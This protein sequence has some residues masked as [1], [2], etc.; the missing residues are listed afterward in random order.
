MMVER[1]LEITLIYVDAGI[2]QQ[3]DNV[4]QILIDREHEW[5]V[6]VAVIGVDTTISARTDQQRDEFEIARP[7]FHCKCDGILPPIVYSA[8]LS[9]SG[10][11]IDDLIDRLFERNFDKIFDMGT[12]IEKVLDEAYIAFA[13]SVVERKITIRSAQPCVVARRLTPHNALIGAVE[14]TCDGV[15]VARI[16]LPHRHVRQNPIGLAPFFKQGSPNGVI[17]KQREQGELTVDRAIASMIIIG[18]RVW[19]W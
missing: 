16:N 8:V 19:I 4:D 9:F 2:D 18:N 11:E 7:A 14:E 13:H 6:I 1:P 3:V 15:P 5:R 10:R 12:C 17:G